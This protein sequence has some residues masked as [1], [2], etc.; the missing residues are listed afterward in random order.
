[1]K[2]LPKTSLFGSQVKK[3]A[4]YVKHLINSTKYYKGDYGTIAFNAEK[5]SYRWLLQLKVYNQE[6][7][8]ISRALEAIGWTPEVAEKVLV[9]GT[10]GATVFTY[11]E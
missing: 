2:S 10:H 1:M 3:D 7:E 9:S 4:E 5:S 6:C 11:N 8:R